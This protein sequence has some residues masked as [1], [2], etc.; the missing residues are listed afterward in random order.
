MVQDANAE[1]LAATRIAKIND[2]ASLIA[3]VQVKQNGKTVY[4]SNSLY[5]VTN[6]KN[7]LTMSQDSANGSATSKY[8][9]LDTGDTTVKDGSDAIYNK[10]FTIRSAFVLAGKI[11]NSIIP[12]NKF[13]FFEG[14]ER[15][16]LPPSQIQI[17]PKL[18]DDA[19]LIHRNNGV[20]AGKVVVN[21][22]VLWIPR[23]VFNSDGLNFVQNN[24]TKTEW[25][26][27]RE[28]VQVSQYSEQREATFKSKT[29]KTYICLSSTNS[30]IIESRTQ[31]SYS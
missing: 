31:P 10:G 17:S 6:I 9:Y 20:D 3:D 5:R 24:N 16:L 25:V 23:M 22:L 2:A 1:Y 21:K 8:F 13:S 7:L 14:L 11:Q 15:N 28:M 26:Y 29:T 12:L 4:D 18:T 19:T 27:L 30:K